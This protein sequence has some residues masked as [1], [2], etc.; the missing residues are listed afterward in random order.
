VTAVAWR[1][2]LP[3]RAIA[4]VLGGTIMLVVSCGGSGS[5]YVSSPSTHTFLK[6]P[7]GW[8]VF[9]QSEI[10]TQ[11]SAVASP[12]FPFLAVIDADPKP[13]ID[14]S[15]SDGRYPFGLVRVRDLGL[16]EHDAFSLASLR[17]EVVKVDDILQNDSTAVSVLGTPKLLTHKGLR[18]TKLEYSVRLNGTDF[19]VS[20]TGFVDGPTRRVWLLILGCESSCFR[21]NAAAIHRVADSWIVQGS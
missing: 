11:T 12:P 8:R 18:G 5:T 19:T 9:R 10:R 17:N 7:A 16:A 3:R 13:S 4:T 15:F 21:R 14:H 20:Q 1:I 6:V 2:R